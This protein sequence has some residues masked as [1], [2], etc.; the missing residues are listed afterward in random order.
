MKKYII[1]LLFMVCS[2]SAF[3]FDFADG[4]CE[5]I[6]LGGDLELIVKTTLQPTWLVTQN[7][8]YGLKKSGKI[9]LAPDYLPEDVAIM[10]EAD[11]L[12]FMNKTE[13][14]VHIYDTE[15][16]EEIFTHYYQKMDTLD[17]TFSGFEFHRVESKAGRQYLLL[18]RFDSEALSCE[19]MIVRFYRRRGELRMQKL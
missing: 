16:G 9:V 13:R 12:V 1:L 14:N 17:N 18:E 15:N 7:T 11:L 3:S 8:H 5:Y 6:K 10:A 4:K 19:R 2:L